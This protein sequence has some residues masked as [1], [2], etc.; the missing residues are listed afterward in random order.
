M[1]YQLRAAT[2]ADLESIA[3]LFPRLASFELSA[4]RSAEDL[5]R[6]DLQLLNDW[7]VG[8]VP[9]CIVLV[10][11]ASDQTILG[12]AM[13]QLRAELLSHAPSAH[14]EV[15]VVRDGFEGQGI[16][17]ALIHA[18]EAE[19]RVRGA[20][21]MTLHVFSTNTRARALYERLGY[22][23]ELIRCIKFLE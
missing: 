6:G 18:I 4:Q 10:A 16:G 20:Q 5:W 23:S 1:S 14:L 3:A 11:I 17:Q 22:A 2:T 9:E 13:A 15:L 19:V 12:V 7:S 21:S 8:K